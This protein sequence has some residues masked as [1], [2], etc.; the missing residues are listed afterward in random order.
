MLSVRQQQFVTYFLGKAQGNGTLAATMAGYGNPSVAA[1]RLIRNDKVSRRIAAK[2]DKAAMDVDE[3]LAR[4][5]TLARS[6][7]NNFLAFDPDADPSEPPKIDFR[8]AKKR[9]SL[10]VVKK[11]KQTTRKIKD[12]DEWVTEREIEVELYD[13]HPS[14][15]L[16]VKYHGLGIV[17][18]RDE[19][20]SRDG[21]GSA[22]E[23]VAGRLDSLK[24][25]RDV[26]AA[27]R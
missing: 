7:A 13:P 27:S 19:D 11:M 6:D 16:L 20:D 17:A 9:N 23:T 2:L 22:E 18:N 24:A 21:E 15:A 3:V 25:Q 5:T 14:L 1:S 4:I 10:G 12:G 26:E 8:R